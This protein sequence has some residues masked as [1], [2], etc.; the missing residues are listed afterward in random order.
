MTSHIL[1]NNGLLKLGIAKNLL[2]NL[3]GFSEI[4]I[5]ARL[6]NAALRS[7]KSYENAI[8]EE[9]VVFL[10]LIILRRF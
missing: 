9:V 2:K 4:P 7:R 1:A 5:N 6:N 8:L 10:K 3:Q